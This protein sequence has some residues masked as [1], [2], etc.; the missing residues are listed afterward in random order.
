MDAKT[1][2][3]TADL[4]AVRGGQLKVRVA[5]WTMKARRELKPRLMALVQRA[6]EQ[7]QTDLASLFEFAEEELCFIVRESITAES[8]EPLTDE[9]WDSLYWLED[10]PI[11]TQAVWTVCIERVGG[12]EVAGKLLAAATQFLAAGA[13]RQTS[14]PTNLKPEDSP[15]SPEEATEIPNT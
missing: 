7:G 6:T 8:G 14:T 5:P 1:A 15:S 11:L 9:E 4:V 2:F 10:L 3:P 12:G 13:L